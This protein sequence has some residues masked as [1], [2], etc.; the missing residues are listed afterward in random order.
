[1][2]QEHTAEEWDE[3]LRAGIHT[4]DFPAPVRSK[5]TPIEMNGVIYS[6]QSYCFMLCH[7]YC[8]FFPFSLCPS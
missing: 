4:M 5:I 8:L 2:H 3:E 6:S 7:L 1:M